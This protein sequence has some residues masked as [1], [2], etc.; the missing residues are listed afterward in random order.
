MTIDRVLAQT[1]VDFDSAFIGYVDKRIG[2]AGGQDQIAAWEALPELFKMYH[3]L[4]ALDSDVSN[5]GFQQYFGRYASYPPFVIAAIRGLD[6]VS[7]AHAPLAREAV[8]IFVH[9][10]P[11]LQ[12]VMELFEIPASPLLTETDINDRFRAAGFL[13]HLRIAWLEANR[14]AVRT[15]V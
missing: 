6:R 14:D 9:Y 7:P 12:P 1:G 15:A 10:M 13:L 3:A 8:A 5:G 4:F 2:S 11:K